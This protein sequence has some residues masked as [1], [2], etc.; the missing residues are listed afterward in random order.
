MHDLWPSTFSKGLLNGG[1]YGIP[2]GSNDTEVFIGCE[3]R[4]EVLCSG[5]LM[6]RLW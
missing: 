3:E 6:Y 5:L 1:R 2:F 4:F